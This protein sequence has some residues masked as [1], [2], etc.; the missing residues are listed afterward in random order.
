LTT[1]ISI[2]QPWA[3]LI[4]HGIKRIEN[5]SWLPPHKLYGQ[6][7]L[8][9]AAAAREDPRD[10]Q[11]AQEICERIGVTLPTERPTGV[12]V[13]IVTL[14]GCIGPS[15]EGDMVTDIPNWEECGVE[16]SANAWYN[17]G[18]IGWVLADARTI[19]PFPV[20]GRLGLYQVEIAN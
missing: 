2:R 13:G 12:A 7:L 17:E 20:K 14:I 1:A 6:E 16:E 18:S 5:R 3:S 15:E 10:T 4:A 19:P 9:C 8:I 11:S